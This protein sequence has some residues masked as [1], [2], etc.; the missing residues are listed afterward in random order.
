MVEAVVYETVAVHDFADYIQGCINVLDEEWARSASSRFV[1]DSKVTGRFPDKTYFPNMNI[2]PRA[3]SHDGT[4]W[5][6]GT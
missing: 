1:L 5:T 6:E 3:C 2:H 4:T